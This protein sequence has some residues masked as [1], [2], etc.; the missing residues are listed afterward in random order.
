M[1]PVDKYEADLRYAV[2]GMARL[3]LIAHAENE[4]AN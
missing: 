3:D 1:G 2:R 4:A